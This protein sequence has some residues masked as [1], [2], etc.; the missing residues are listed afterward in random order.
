MGE[1]SVNYA[2]VYIFV[3]KLIGYYDKRQGATVPWHG[4]AINTDFR[5]AMGISL[6]P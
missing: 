3:A 5:T 2:K 1:I 6:L 4:Y